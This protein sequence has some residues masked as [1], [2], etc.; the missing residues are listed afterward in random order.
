PSKIPPNQFNNIESFKF[1]NDEFIEKQYYMNL[2]PYI[3]DYCPDVYANMLDFNEV[4]D[5]YKKGDEIYALYA[6]VPDVSHMALIIKNQL[7]EEFNVQSI[8]NVDMLFNLTE[9]IN[10]DKE[11]ENTIK[12]AVSPDQLLMVATIKAGY[13]PITVNLWNR[14]N[15]FH[16]VFKLN[17]ENCKPYL[18]EDTDIF[19]VYLEI[20]DS[21]FRKSYFVEPSQSVIMS[22]YSDNELPMWLSSNFFSEVTAGFLYSKNNEE[23]FMNHYSAVMLD[24]KTTA[25]C[26]A[27]SV[28][29]IFVP[30]TCTQPEKALSF[31]NWLFTD[32]EIAALLTF[33]TDKGP[34]PGYQFSED[35]NMTYNKDGHTIYMFHHLIANFSDRLFPYDNRTFDMT[36]QYKNLAKK[37]IYPPLSK[38]IESN[39]GEAVS[40]FLSMTNS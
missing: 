31:V 14:L 7:K 25:F 16:I 22:R 40:D 4:T 23:H 26:N 35:Q 20:F 36:G 8:E 19:D 21:F 37:A 24:A 1:F 32:E 18:I 6:G 2:S 29:P 30:Y 15:H 27:N 13:Y 17:D 39:H 3:N 10:N 38:V 11:L 12:V 33:G 9:R 34:L 5:L 28:Q